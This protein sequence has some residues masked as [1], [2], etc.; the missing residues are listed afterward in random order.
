MRRSYHYEETRG[1]DQLEHLYGRFLGLPPAVVV[2]ALWL[3]G[4]TLV[5]ACVL[6][7]YLCVLLLAAA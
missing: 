3:V 5:G 6:M 2:S 4:L 7:F 1:I